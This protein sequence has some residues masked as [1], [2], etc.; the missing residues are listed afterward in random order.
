[1]L[2]NK[3]KAVVIVSTSTATAVS[4]SGTAKLPKTPKKAGASAQAKLKKV[5]K[6]AI[7]GKLTRFTLNFPATLKSAVAALTR[8][9]SVTVKIEATATD[10]TGKVVKDRAQLKLKG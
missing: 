1:M 2:P 7:P 9:S 10:V 6:N 3:S 4:V 5:T 8:G